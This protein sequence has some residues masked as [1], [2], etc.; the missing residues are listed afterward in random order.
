VAVAFCNHR[1][2]V[3]RRHAGRGSAVARNRDLLEAMVVVLRPQNAG[4]SCEMLSAGRQAVAVQFGGEY[5][6]SH[7]FRV[8]PANIAEFT[9]SL[10]FIA[11]TTLLTESVSHRVRP[12]FRS[13]SSISDIVCQHER[14]KSIRNP[15]PITAAQLH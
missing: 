6:P 5:S 11:N 12:D 10:V 2:E 15:R 1:A 3:I 8:L 13:V 9:I 14:W 4:D 7:Y